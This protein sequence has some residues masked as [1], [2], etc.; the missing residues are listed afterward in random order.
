[1]KRLLLMLGLLLASG[2]VSAQTDSANSE[3]LIARIVEV[4]KQQRQQVKDLVIL[5]EYIKGE[6]KDDGT[7]EEKVRFHK[8]ISIK[9]LADTAWMHEEYLSGMKEGKQMSEKDCQD[10]A[11]ED[12]EK[13]KRRSTPNISYPMVRP[14]YPEKR[15]L[16]Q[17]DYLGVAGERVDGY[18]CH[19]FKVTAKEP[20]DTLINGDYF[21]DT[22]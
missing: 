3:Q 17:I 16:Y 5:S 13:K 22:E 4:E 2:S 8:R 21:F 6:E 19:Y 20:A 14:F 18:L 15:A 7:F 11:K 9:F 1:M 10:A 12:R